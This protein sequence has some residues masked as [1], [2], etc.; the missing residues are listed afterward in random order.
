MSNHTPGPWIADYNDVCASRDGQRGDL[1]AMTSSDDHG[2]KCANARLMAAAPD[3]LKAL[4][5]CG[6]VC[7]KVVLGPPHD[8]RCEA[9][10]AAIAK[11]K[12]GE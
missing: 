6:C 7:Y 5:G 11:A 8:E 1:L 4:E 9:V 3:M 2:E 12:G 10:V